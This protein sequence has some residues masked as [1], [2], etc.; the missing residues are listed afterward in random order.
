MNKKILSVLTFTAALGVSGVADAGL[1]DRGHGLIY[2]DVLN[3]TWLQDANYAQTSGYDTDGLMNWTAATAWAAQLV[4][5]GYDDWRLPMIVDTGRSGCNFAYN[6]TDCGY[7]VDTSASEL[8]YMFHVNL[9][10]LSASTSNGS[11]RSGFSG[12]DWGMV[13]TQFV[14][15]ETGQTVSFQN[16]QN[17]HTR[18]RD[19]QSGFF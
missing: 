1:I 14:D 13:N 3:I 15:A 19:L 6:S 8:A 18:Q 12:T 16:F 4:Y 9:G 5:G 11:F 17:F 10:N 2:D 7:N